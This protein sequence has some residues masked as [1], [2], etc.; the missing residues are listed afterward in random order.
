[1]LN[2]KKKS[3]DW[4]F[5]LLTKSLKD[6]YPCVILSENLKGSISEFYVPLEM[7]EFTYISYRA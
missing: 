5:V 3:L 2:K 1:M 7:G 4:S 6:S